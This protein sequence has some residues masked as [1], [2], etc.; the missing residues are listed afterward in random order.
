MSDVVAVVVVVCFQTFI[1]VLLSYQD[2]RADV[3]KGSLSDFPPDDIV[4]NKIETGWILKHFSLLAF[5]WFPQCYQNTPQITT[6]MK[7]TT[8]T[9]MKTTTTTTMTTTITQQ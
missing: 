1:F 6:T 4:M 5:C 9:M 3:S 7:T 2:C 8:T